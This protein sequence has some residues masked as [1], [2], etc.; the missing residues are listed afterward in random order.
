MYYFHFSLVFHANLTVGLNLNLTDQ[1]EL[2]TNRAQK[3]L[4]EVH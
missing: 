3:R 4:Y 1:E 2:K